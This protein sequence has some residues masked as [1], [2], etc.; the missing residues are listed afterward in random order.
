[1]SAPTEPRHAPSASANGD[2]VNRVQQLRLDNQ[3]G[4]VRRSR[5]SWLPWVLCA[6]LAVAWVA[7]GVKWLRAPAA[8]AGDEG[9]QPAGGARTA[10]KPVAPGEILFQLKGNLIPSLQIAV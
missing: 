5:G 1:M 10:D 6:M 2:L 3:V 8:P 9:G 7:V 4:T